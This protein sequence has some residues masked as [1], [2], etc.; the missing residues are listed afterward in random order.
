MG[1]SLFKGHNEFVESTSIGD[2]PHIITFF[3][4]SSDNDFVN[5]FTN[6]KEY[7]KRFVYL[8]IYLFIYNVLYK[9]Q[10]HQTQSS[11]WFAYKCQFQGFCLSCGLHVW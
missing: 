10:E 2:I 11:K 3:V 7:K 9:V 6:G 1:N 5:C 4:S 8:F